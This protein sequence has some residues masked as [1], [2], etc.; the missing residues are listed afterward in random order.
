MRTLRD[1]HLPAGVVLRR[2]CY[3]VLS[4]VCSIGLGGSD[5][6]R[7]RSAFAVPVSLPPAKSRRLLAVVSPS[8]NGAVTHTNTTYKP[9]L[10]HPSPS[11]LKLGVR[12]L[13]TTTD[14][15]S[16][17]GISLIAEEVFDERWARPHRHWALGVVLLPACLDRLTLAVFVA[18][19]SAS[20]HPSLLSLN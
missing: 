4:F 20:L 3:S 17:W 14:R 5:H 11:S 6:P 12:D 2:L 9:N 19:A 1:V 8:S 16:L 15:P 18:A 7:A 13:P 10:A